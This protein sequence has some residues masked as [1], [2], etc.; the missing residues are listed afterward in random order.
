MDFT[1]APK[2][3]DCTKQPARAGF[4]MHTLDPLGFLIDLFHWSIADLDINHRF[5][6]QPDRPASEW[7][8]QVTPEDRLRRGALW[9]RRPVCMQLCVLPLSSVRR[10]TRHQ[11]SVRACA[12][13]LD[14]RRGGP[15]ALCRFPPRT[16]RVLQL[17]TAVRRCF[18]CRS[19][20]GFLSQG[21]RAGCR[22]NKVVWSLADRCWSCS[23]GCVWKKK[24]KR[25]LLRRVRQ[26]VYLPVANCGLYAINQAL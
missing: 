3:C 18:R 6:D 17:G 8:N 4:Y 21:C 25:K 20:F 22:L 23:R 11:I 15:D 5:H 16:P 19:A 1:C 14:D 9:W 26:S 24:K 7:I 13:L 12:P 10:A 2:C